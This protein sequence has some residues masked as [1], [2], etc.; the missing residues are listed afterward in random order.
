MES[1]ET[2]YNS[3]DMKVI[4]WLADPDNNLRQPLFWCQ[5]LY[6]LHSSSHLTGFCISIDCVL[7]HQQG[8]QVLP[9]CLH[10][11]VCIAMNLQISLTTFSAQSLHF[12]QVVSK[13]KQMQIPLGWSP[14]YGPSRPAADVPVATGQQLQGWHMYALSVSMCCTP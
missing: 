4:K 1:P 5:A 9:C 14:Q 6:L 12:Y 8:L 13:P 2:R 11:F 7:T 3:T 10:A